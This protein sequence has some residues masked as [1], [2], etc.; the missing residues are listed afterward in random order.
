MT[1]KP[2]LRFPPRYDSARIC[3]SVKPQPA[4]PGAGSGGSAMRRRDVGTTT[5]GAELAGIGGRGR[6]AH[7]EA[8]SGQ[9]PCLHIPS[10]VEHRAVGHRMLRACSGTLLARCENAALGGLSIFRSFAGLQG[11]RSEE[12]TSE[13][14]SRGHLVCRLLLEKKKLI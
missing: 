12:H 7:P 6:T 8:S 11:A 2:S 13:L 5:D 14:Q 1:H 3:A 9:V 10:G 4:G